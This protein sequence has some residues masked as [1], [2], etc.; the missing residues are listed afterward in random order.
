MTERVDFYVLRSAAG[1]QRWSFACRL[2]EKIQ[3][4]DLRAVILAATDEDARELDTLLW[5]FSD[6]SFVPHALCG[7]DGA[8]DPATPVHLTANAELAPTADVL[9]NLSDRM[10]P[11]TER[12]A[13]IA[14][15]VDGDEGTRTRARERF[16]AYR[17]MRVPV[18]TH[19]LG[20]GDGG[21]EDG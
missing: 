11:G 20:D 8:A 14:E 15:I 17:E 9:L 7:A 4:R 16:K 5:T 1:R 10:P 21:G 12:F 6:R 3:L 13:R 2:A 19:M 18:Q